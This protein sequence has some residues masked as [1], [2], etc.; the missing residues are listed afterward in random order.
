MEVHEKKKLKRLKAMES[1]EDEEE[2]GEEIVVIYI[3]MCVTIFNE[4]CFS[5][6]V[7]FFGFAYFFIKGFLIKTTCTDLLVTIYSIPNN[8][9][10][11]WF[12]DFM[13]LS[14]NGPFNYLTQIID[15]D[16]LLKLFMFS[17]FFPN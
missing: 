13:W 8:E 4:L 17:P 6:T 11:K 1:D 14:E 15:V 10:F 5:D 16:I 12:I 9:S 3:P 7:K 2:E